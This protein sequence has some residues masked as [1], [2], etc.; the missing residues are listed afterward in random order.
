MSEELFKVYLPDGHNTKPYSKKQIR[1]SFRAGKIPN[2]ATVS[3]YGRSVSVAEF[4]EETLT[5]MSLDVTTPAAGLP[6]VEMATEQQLKFARSLGIECKPGMT[7][8][9]ISELIGEARARQA[10]ESAA[11]VDSVDGAEFRR[12]LEERIRA[13]ILAEMR[14][15]GDVPLSK[16]TPE[17]VARHFNDVRYMNM[18]I[19]YS[20]N[21]SFERLIA[22]ADS[23]ELAEC[24]GA[25]LAF[26][27]PQGMPREDLR[28]LL[29]AVMW[30]F[31]MK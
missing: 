31:D 25:T 20:E 10:T 4:V 9:R 12:E 1:A 29:I 3:V 5:G 2:G 6:V 7:K 23:G 24:N 13:E 26:G 16:A 21:N 28:D 14:A 11:G 19:I 30:G 27:T 15:T 22:A 18:L 17:D 8:A